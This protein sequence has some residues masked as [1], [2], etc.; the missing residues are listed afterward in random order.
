MPRESAVK[1]SGW[2]ECQAQVAGYPGAK[3]KA[4]ATREAALEAFD[5]DYEQFEGQ[6]TKTFRLPSTELAGHGVILDSVCVDAACSGYPGDLE[7]RGV[8]TQDGTEIFHRGP[9]PEG[10]VNIGEFLAI[11]NAL[12]LLVRHGRDCPVYS[13]SHTA[14]VWV[15]EKHSNTKLRPT[16]ANRRLFNLLERA[17][18]WLATHTYPNPLLKWETQDWGENPAD[19]GRK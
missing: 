19:F 12:A 10:S 14:L 1:I 11:V 2:T 5:G 15:R 3:F 16:V 9:F 17:E 13:D 4:F 18:R 6:N 8:D 7:Y